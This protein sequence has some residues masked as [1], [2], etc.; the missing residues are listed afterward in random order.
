M[1]ILCLNTWRKK[2]KNNFRV[3][4]ENLG[5]KGLKILLQFTR[6]ELLNKRRLPIGQ[7]GMEIRLSDV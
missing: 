6:P 2:T 7:L 5:T 3:K 4:G 1:H